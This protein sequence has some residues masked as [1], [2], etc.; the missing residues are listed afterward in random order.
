MRVKFHGQIS[1]SK[2]QP[3]SGAQEASLGNHEFTSQT[4][5]NADCVPEADRCKFVDDLR[6]LEKINF[7]SIGLASHNYKL[8]VPSNIPSHGQIIS[9]EH[10]NQKN[11]LKNQQ[12]D[13]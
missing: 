4:N 6:F 8:Q 5:N 11:I 3:G 9:N 12:M 2:T 10:L 1:E 13:H 7:L